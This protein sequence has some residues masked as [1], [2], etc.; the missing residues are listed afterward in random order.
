MVHLDR[1]R[2][3]YDKIK[4]QYG[5]DVKIVTAGKIGTSVIYSESKARSAAD[6]VEEFKLIRLD[7][8][9]EWSRDLRQQQLS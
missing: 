6:I 8:Y 7:D 5:E 4:R 2:A 1:N 9:F 3:H